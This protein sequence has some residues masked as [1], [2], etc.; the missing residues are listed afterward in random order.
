MLL[1]V[2][3]CRTLEMM[4]ND[5]LTLGIGWSLVQMHICAWWCYFE[6]F[7]DE[8]NGFGEIHL[9]IV[10]SGV[11]MNLG[12]FLDVDVFIV[13]FMDFL[14]VVC[15]CFSTTTTWMFSTKLHVLFPEATAWFCDEFWCFWKLRRR[16]ECIV[17]GLWTVD[18]EFIRHEFTFVVMMFFRWEGHIVCVVPPPFLPEGTARQAEAQH[19]M[20]HDKCM[21]TYLPSC[22]SRVEKR[23]ECLQWSRGLGLGFLCTLNARRGGGRP[24]R[25]RTSGCN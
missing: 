21:T 8:K 17:N 18:G 9:H 20:L 23:S 5:V 22:V 3:L 25:A 2:S 4:Q 1:M 19:S 11:Q 16:C 14:D 24:Q 15:M 13:E 12:C 6:K 10:Q 7:L